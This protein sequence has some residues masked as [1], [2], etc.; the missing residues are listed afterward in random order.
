MSTDVREVAGLAL[1]A[2][3][4]DDAVA[5]VMSERSGLA[6]FASSEVHQ[7]TLIENCSVMLQIVRDGRIGTA[8]TNRL[9]ED[10]LRELAG[11][12]GEAADGAVAEEGFPGLAPP[13]TL[14]EVEGWDDAVAGIGPEDQARRAARCDRRV[15]G[16]AVRILHERRD[17]AR[18]RVDRRC[19]RV[20]GHDRRRRRS[21]SRRANGESGYASRTTWAEDGMDP[22][23]VGREA[24]DK[25]QRT[26]DAKTLE[27]APYRAVLEPYAF[28]DLVTYFSFDAFGANGLL[29]GRCIS[30]A[31]SAT[32]SS[33][34]RSR[35]RTTGSTRAAC[36]RASTSRACRSSA[37]S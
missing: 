37:C 24:S 22:A 7:P 29:E 35:S 28:A 30:P 17:R 4:G 14:P 2:A 16:R 5:I 31:D 1:E 25:A 11:R 3:K 18:D 6:R 9:D 36:R 26:R 33:T 32:R 13:Q 21:R 34:R 8:S 15:G 10:S 23:A 20:P 12:A 27:P 19:R